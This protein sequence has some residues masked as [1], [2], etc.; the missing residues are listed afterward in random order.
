MKNRLFRVFLS[1]A[2]VV[3]ALIAVAPADEVRAAGERFDVLSV[4]GVGCNEDDIFMTYQTTGLDPANTYYQRTTVTS[5][6]LVYMNQLGSF[7][8][9]DTIGGWAVFSNST[10]GTATGTFP[11]TAGYPVYIEIILES[12]VGV[13]LYAANVE[14]SSCDGVVV[15][16][17]GTS[18]AVISE[19]DKIGQVRVTAPGTRLYQAPGGGV[20]RDSDGQEI[21]VPNQTAHDP[22]QD[23]YDVL[24]QMELDGT[25]WVSIFVGDA[26]RSVWIP[27]GG[28]VSPIY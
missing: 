18:L 1:T 21:W 4:D 17:S 25:T 2:I 11:M 15:S 13:Q 24:E 23:T 5:N 14:L 22:Y 20:V 3:A 26:A 19:Y 10:G 28:I 8:D 16:I 6:G 9:S 12:P 27:V 7:I